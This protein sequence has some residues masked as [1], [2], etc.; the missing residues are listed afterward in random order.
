MLC[1]APCTNGQA[2]AGDMGI[3]M[4]KYKRDGVGERY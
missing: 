1:R 2:Q 4:S 3:A